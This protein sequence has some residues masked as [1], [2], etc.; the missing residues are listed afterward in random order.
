MPEL[1]QTW[2]QFPIIDGDITTVREVHERIVRVLPCRLPGSVT[3]TSVHPKPGEKWKVGDKVQ[4]YLEDDVI[5]RIRK[6]ED[7]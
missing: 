6:V 1:T 4:V 5:P 3:I 7:E 2:Y